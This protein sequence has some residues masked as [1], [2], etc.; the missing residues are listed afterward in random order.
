VNGTI[1]NADEDLVATIDGA[2]IRV[3]GTGGAT[4]ARKKAQRVLATLL[5]TDI[6]ASTEHVGRVG[7]AKWNQLLDE[8]H[9]AVHLAARIQAAAAPGEILVSSTVH[10]LVSGGDVTFTDR[11]EHD[12]KGIDGPRRLFAVLD[13]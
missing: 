3:E 9:L 10:E 12:L 5:F 6:V 4:P 1:R 2:L 11:G 13:R 7:D 8:H